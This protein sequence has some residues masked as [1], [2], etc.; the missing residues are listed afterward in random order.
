MPMLSDDFETRGTVPATDLRPSP[1]NPR[2]HFPEADIAGLAVTLNEHGVLEPL[3]VRPHGPDDE[4]KDGTWHRPGG[5]KTPYFAAGKWTNLGWFEIINGERRYRAGQMF[6]LAEY[7][8]TVRNFTDAEVLVI[9]LITFVQRTDLTVSEEAA[10]FRDLATAGETAESIAAKVS[11]PLGYV[12]NLLRIARLP[13]WALAK[14]DAGTLP[15]ATAELVAKVPGEASRL[16]ALYC[17][18]LDSKHPSDWSSQFKS[19]A[20]WAAAAQAISDSNI[21]SYRETTELIRHHFTRELKTAPFDRKVPLLLVSEATSCDE[22]P[23]RAGNDPDAT[24]EGVR[25]D[26]CLNPDCYRK[27]EDAYRHEVETSFAEKKILPADL[28]AE[29][30]DRPPRGWCR[31]DEPVTG[32]DL[33]SEFVGYQS[34]TL[35]QKLGKDK[36][37]QKYFAFGRNGKAVLLVKTSDAKKALI[38]AGVLKKPATPKP[39]ANGSAKPAAGNLSPPA[40]PRKPLQTDID[41]EAAVLAAERIVDCGKLDQLPALLLAT[42]CAAR[43]LLDV[44]EAGSEILERVFMLPPIGYSF[45]AAQDAAKKVDAQ[46]GTWSPEELSRLLLAFSMA[47]FANQAY[48]RDNTDSALFKDVQKAAAFDWKALQ[49]DAE[50]S[51]CRRGTCMVCGCTEENCSGCMLRTGGPCE[52]TSATQT[53]CSAC[54]PI[55]EKPAPGIVNIQGRQSEKLDEHAI[56]TIGHVLALDPERPPEGL[57]KPLVVNLQDLARRQV[58]DELRINTSHD[59]PLFLGML[60]GNLIPHPETVKTIDEKIDAS[61][62]SGKFQ[63]TLKTPASVKPVE[64]GGKL[65]VS[66]GGWEKGNGE[67]QDTLVRLY[68]LD[69]FKAA[70]PKRKVTLGPNT[71]AG[72]TDGERENFY[73]GVHVKSGKHEYA[74]GPAEEKMYVTNAAPKKVPAS[75][76]KGKGKKVTA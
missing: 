64:L 26:I 55:A 4:F 70:F 19:E 75:A 41:D 29:G 16:K 51:L 32:T 72:M 14:I 33:N 11:K 74:I 44:G 47:R 49:A 22:C 7:P 36:L 21:L 24:A 23:T 8:V 71:G 62:I 52:W 73:F 59:K 65:Y 67:R 35:Q 40:G 61:R 53:L 30:F 31:F 69:A 46:L 15:R 58:A 27:K 10:G 5:A 13:D 76:P 57:P 66:S 45:T 25:A 63:G 50:R 39:G 3:L 38:E 20:T 2:K 42:R 28:N 17:V 18:L 68:P 56:R 43:E 37:P 1:T 12:R 34:W 9:Q 60:I 6:H 48:A 54:L